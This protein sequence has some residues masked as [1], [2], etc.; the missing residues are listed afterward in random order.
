[1]LAPASATWMRYCGLLSFLGEDF[2]NLS[3]SVQLSS[4]A[5][6]FWRSASGSI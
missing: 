3:F 4:F 6:V 5:L 1:M 2:Q